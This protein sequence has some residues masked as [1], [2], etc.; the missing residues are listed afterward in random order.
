[1]IATEQPNRSL[2]NKTQIRRVEAVPAQM[3]IQTVALMAEQTSYL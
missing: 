1:M 2:G 3:V